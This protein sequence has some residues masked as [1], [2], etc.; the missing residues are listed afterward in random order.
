VLSATVGATLAFLVARYLFHDRVN[1]LVGKRPGLKAVN[2][3]IS[4]E[5]WKIVVLLRLSPVLPFNLQNYFY[6]VT[7]V[8]LVHYVPAT[9]LGILPGTLLYVYLGSVGKAAS[10]EGGGPLQWL[11]FATGLLATVVVAWFV[12]TKAKAKLKEIG[13]DG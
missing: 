6:G 3:A 10:G 12:T 8:K 11:L 9:F 7:D 13:V 4:E 5:G 1:A 2:Q